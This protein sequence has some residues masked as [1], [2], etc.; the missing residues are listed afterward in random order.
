MFLFEN[1]FKTVKSSVK[2]HRPRN[3]SSGW[4]FH[5]TGRL[6]FRKPT[7][8]LASQSVEIDFSPGSS[9]V[10]SWDVFDKRNSFLVSYTTTAVGGPD[11]NRNE[12]T[13]LSRFRKGVGRCNCRDTDRVK[14]SRWRLTSHE[15]LWI[16][17]SNSWLWISSIVH[18]LSVFSRQREI[19]ISVSAMFSGLE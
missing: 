15:W 13:L 6:R 10:T 14:I 11:L 9:R 19:L 16:W 18:V 8:R 2:S 3:Y 5:G 12:L 7:L 17:C 1:V 4:F